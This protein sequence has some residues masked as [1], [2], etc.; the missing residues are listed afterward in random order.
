MLCVWT[1]YYNCHSNN[2]YGQGEFWGVYENCTCMA[3]K[4][5][6]SGLINRAIIVS[7][8]QAPP[9]VRL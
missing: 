5:F 6:D 2:I 7:S 4:Y 8:I 3:T 9:V 1:A